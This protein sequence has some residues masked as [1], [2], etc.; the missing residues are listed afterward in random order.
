M[1]GMIVVSGYMSVTALLLALS[2][3]SGIPGFDYPGVVFLLIEF[4]LCQQ[5]MSYLNSAL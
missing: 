3:N 5:N 4:S 1:Q 2:L